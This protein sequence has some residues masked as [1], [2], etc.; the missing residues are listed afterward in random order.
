MDKFVL[1]SIRCTSLTCCCCHCSSLFQATWR[2]VALHRLRG[3][4]TH[5][6]WPKLPH[7]QP[8]ISATC[9]PVNHAGCALHL[10]DLLPSLLY[11]ATWRGVARLPTMKEVGPS[12]VA[13]TSSHCHVTCSSLLRWE[14][15]LTQRWQSG[16]S[17]RCVSNRWPNEAIKAQQSYRSSLL[18]APCC[19]TS[20][21]MCAHFCCAGRCH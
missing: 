11:Q 6:Q 4:G 19:V 3:W 14:A 2:G 8:C 15:L 1:C 13:Q 9:D 7:Y 21:M 16:C 12:L 17:A 18:T 5:P 10:V 20:C